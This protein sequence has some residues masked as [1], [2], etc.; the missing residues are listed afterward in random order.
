M[1]IIT[2]YIW[3][4]LIILNINLPPSIFLI[5]INMFK[6]YE[7]YNV[8]IVDKFI[9][10]LF[11]IKKQGNLN[12]HDNWSLLIIRYSDKPFYDFIIENQ[13]IIK[14]IIIIQKIIIE[15]I[16]NKNY[17]SEFILTI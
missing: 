4:I 11:D 7:I 1:P 5:K 6:N 14:I 15:F 8:D 17:G 3:K 10:L 16:N 2:E 13:H 9:K 12:K